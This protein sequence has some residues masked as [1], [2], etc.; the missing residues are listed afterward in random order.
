MP[1]SFPK[2][3]V[4]G[5]N[6]NGPLGRGFTLNPEGSHA[7]VAE[8]S[9]VA[10]MT[11]S[12]YRYDTA[13][14]A[15][16]LVAQDFLNQPVERVATFGGWAATP[17]ALWVCLRVDD[18][19]L[20]DIRVVSFDVSTWAR[21]DLFDIVDSDMGEVR[22]MANIAKVY[23][24][25]YD[26]VGDQIHRLYAP[27]GSSYTTLTVPTGYDVGSPVWTGADKLWFPTAIVG[28]APG[29]DRGVFEYDAGAS[30]WTFH[31]A[32]PETDPPGTGNQSPWGDIN[33]NGREILWHGFDGPADEL[34]NTVIRFGTGMTPIVHLNMVPTEYPAGVKFRAENAI[35]PDVSLLGG[36]AIF[37]ITGEISGGGGRITTPYTSDQT[38]DGWSMPM[39]FVGVSNLDAL[40]VTKFTS[41]QTR[42]SVGFL[43]L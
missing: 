35:R 8:T 36:E 34:C 23:L 29:D 28:W 17:N 31:R 5:L 18:V 1:A 37:L 26:A 16:T 33:S 15:E 20:N 25:F 21:T 2:F 12:I 22:Y 32:P 13:S 40:D 39:M 19:P 9:S 14:F 4:G 6:Y 30:T 24:T 11:G 41:Q 38:D 10:G 3:H 27:D 43:A 7:F 42:P